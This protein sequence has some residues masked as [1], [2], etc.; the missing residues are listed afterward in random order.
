M[1]RRQRLLHRMLATAA[2]AAWPVACATTDE[3]APPVDDGLLQA[4]AD[5]GLSAS[6]LREGRVLYV[7]KCTRCHGPEP[8]TAYSRAE[9]DTI[10]PRMAAESRLTA[11]EE[12]SLRN[13]INAILAVSTRP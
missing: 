6:S 2:L 10:V 4:S 5:L 11:L 9:W 12:E 7:T 8:V 3:L 13:Y 1:P